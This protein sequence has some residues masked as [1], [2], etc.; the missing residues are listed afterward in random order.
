MG[1]ERLG[2]FQFVA[3]VALDIRT[4]EQNSSPRRCAGVGRLSLILEEMSGAA[5][6]MPHLPGNPTTAT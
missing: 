3:C 6:A 1:S 4:I 2:R 5:A